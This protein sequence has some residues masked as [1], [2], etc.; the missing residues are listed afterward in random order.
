MLFERL[1]PVVTAGVAMTLDLRTAKVDNRWIW[2]SAGA[3]VA[4]RLLE[5]GA[6]ALPWCLAGGLIPVLLLGGLFVFRMMGAGDIKL[7]GSLGCVMGT[8]DALKCMGVSLALGA[9]VS[10]AVL[11]SCGDICRR[12]CYFLTYVCSGLNEGRWSAYRQTG[13]SSPEHFH[14]TVPVFLSVALYAGGIY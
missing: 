8:G 6:D 13:I 3:G 9:A 4:F 14:F 2:F 10:L 11:V 12:F 7:F 1:L 5:R